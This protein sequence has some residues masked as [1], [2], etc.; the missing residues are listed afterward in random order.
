MEGDWE[1]GA[2]PPSRERE[3]SRCMRICLHS[4]SSG[5]RI[6]PKTLAQHHGVSCQKA[7]LIMP[8]PHIVPREANKWFYMNLSSFQIVQL[9]KVLYKIWYC[10]S[11]YGLKN[12]IKYNLW[13]NT[14]LVEYRLDWQTLNPVVSSREERIGEERREAPKGFLLHLWCFMTLIKVCNKYGNTKAL[15]DSVAGL[16]VLI[17]LLSVYIWSIL[18][19]KNNNSL[20]AKWNTGIYIFLL[21]AIPSLWVAYWHSHGTHVEVRPE[22]IIVWMLPKRDPWDLSGLQPV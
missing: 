22:W 17:A 10:I 11:I 19:L 5:T 8:G 3:P 12:I 2:R 7:S 16:W 18:Q 4:E 14:Y 1:P 15:L 6:M 13:I 9:H 20:Q 21:K